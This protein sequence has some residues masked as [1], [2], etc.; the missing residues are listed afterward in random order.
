MSDFTTAQLTELKQNYAR[1]VKTVQKGDERVEFRSLAEMAAL[2][3]RLEGELNPST[4]AGQHY[5]T[6]GRGFDA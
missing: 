3:R 6:F 1:G 5:P 4:T 2:I